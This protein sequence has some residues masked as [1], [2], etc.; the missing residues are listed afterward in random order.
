MNGFFKYNRLFYENLEFTIMK[1]EEL[2][3]RLLFL[4]PM[5]TMIFSENVKENTTHCKNKISYVTIKL[6]SKNHQGYS[7]LRDTRE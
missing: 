2:C 5:G 4:L 7:S 3:E 6:T 1:E